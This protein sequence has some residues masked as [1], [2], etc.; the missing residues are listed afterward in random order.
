MHRTRSSLALILLIVPAVP[1]QAPE[2]LG[3]PAVAPAGTTVRDLWDAAYLDGHRAGYVHL[4][5]EQIP[6]PKGEKILRAAQEMNI[7]VRRG[8]DIA[9]IPVLTGTDELPDGTVVGV[10]M[11]QGLGQ[12]VKQELRGRVEGN[13]LVVSATGP[14]ANYQ[15]RIPWDPH[16]VSALGEQD[17]LRR[18]NP[19]PKPGDKF[20]YKTY[21]PIV[22][23]VVTIHVEVENFEDVALQSPTG[24]QRVRLLRVAM[25][26]EEI[27]GV[28]LP[29]Q[30]VW[31]DDQFEVRKSLAN[32]VGVGFLTTERTTEVLARQPIAPH[33]LPDIM[34]RQAIK[35]RQRI[36]NAHRESLLRYRIALNDRDPGKTFANDPPRQT[37]SDVA[38]KSFVLTV[39]AVRQPPAVVPAGVAAPGPEYSSSNYFITSDD[40]KVK[41]QASAAVGSETDPW[42]K[43]QRIEAWVHRNMKVQNFTEAMAPA[44][45]VAESLSG[46]CTEYAM[47]TAAMCR[48]AGVPSRTAIGLVYVDP[49]PARPPF[50]GFHMWT[51]VWVNGAW[52]G[53]DAT[54]GQGSVGPAHLKIADHSWDKTRSMTPLLPLMRV[55]MAQPSIE[56]LAM[57]ARPVVMPR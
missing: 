29:S 39:Q 3:P 17:L 6:G 41:A 7:S 23:A 16:V 36:P 13:Q 43:A 47:L 46:D 22:N 38:D 8:P 9:R 42:K 18:R 14:Q 32:L 51:E 5:V 45:Q 50:F 2:Q 10:F 52:I 28:L 55:M 40:P 26:P 49:P 21:N 11:I 15:K 54:L 56:V 34:D 37:V 48:A 1:A 24:V 57:P 4:K 19:P 12:N 53:L 27:Q 30:I 20:D 31:Y 44:F 35:L 25:T 33:L